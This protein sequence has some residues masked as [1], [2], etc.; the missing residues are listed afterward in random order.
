MRPPTTVR[1]KEKHKQLDEERCTPNTLHI[2]HR[3]Q[4]PLGLRQRGLT[5]IEN[6]GRLYRVVDG[7]WPC[8]EVLCTQ[9]EDHSSSATLE[10][11]SS[12]MVITH[13]DEFD[14]PRSPDDYLGAH[15]QRNRMTRCN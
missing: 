10:N 4:D 3:P 15:E 12:F 11:H 9:F 2:R 14:Q 7:L 13:L 5:P 6:V 1:T 8:C